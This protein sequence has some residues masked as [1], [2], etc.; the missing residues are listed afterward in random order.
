MSDRSTKGD[1]ISQYVGPLI[2]TD[3]R[4]WGHILEK[5]KQHSENSSNRSSALN[6]SFQVALCY[7]IG[8][9]ARRN[10]QKSSLWLERSQKSIA[11]LENE[12]RMLDNALTPG[13]R[14]MSDKIQS[15]SHEGFISSF[16]L[17]HEFRKAGSLSTLK[18]DTVN[19][20]TDLLEEFG[21]DHRLV[22]YQTIIQCDIFEAEGN[23]ASAEEGLTVILARIDKV[24]KSTSNKPPSFIVPVIYRL[25]SVLIAQNKLELAEE[26]TKDLVRSMERN[27]GPD[28]V[29]T[30]KAYVLYGQ[31]LLEKSEFKRAEEIL[32]Q[33]LHGLKRLLGDQHPSTLATRAKLQAVYLNLYD[34]EKLELAARDI[35]KVTGDTQEHEHIEHINSAANLSLALESQGK[36]REAKERGEQALAM[37]EKV[38]GLENATTLAIVGNLGILALRQRDLSASEVLLLRAI[39]GHDELFGKG[40]RDSLINLGHLAMVY[41]TRRD[42]PAAEEMH[43]RVVDGRRT[44]LAQ[45]HLSI[46]ISLANLADCL[47][48]AGKYEDAISTGKQALEGYE[49]ILGKASEPTIGMYRKLASLYEAQGLYKD[50]VSWYHCAHQGLK[51]LRGADHP[52]LMQNGLEM[53]IATRKLDSLAKAQALDIWPSADIQTRGSQ[54]LEARMRVLRTVAL[55]KQRQGDISEAG[56]IHQALIFAKEKSLGPSHPDTLVSMSDLGSLLTNKHDFA[57]AEALHGRVLRRRERALGPMHEDT[58]SSAS[59]MADVFKM[60]GRYDVAEDLYRRASVGREQVLGE[61]HFL[62]LISLNNLAIALMH[63]GELIEAQQL[64]ARVLKTRQRL[65]GNN[66]PH[67]MGSVNNLALIFRKQGNHAKAEQL[68]RQNLDTCKENLGNDHP[69]T[70]TAASNLVATLIHRQNHRT[71]EE[72][73]HDVRQKRESLLGED[74]PSTLSSIALAGR[75]LYLQ[76]HFSR[77]H[78]EYTHLI[79]ATVRVLGQDHPLT[80]SRQQEFEM[81]KERVADPWG[82]LPS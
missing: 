55:K 14:Y 15:W 41:Q 40:N 25:V 35:F 12:K 64:T 3:Y 4:V 28:Q 71:A 54:E 67:T 81:M 78:D 44:V 68:N 42:Y 66:H 32:H 46:F 69:S 50:A 30:L 76:G 36:Y 56:D 61:E 60:Q 16:E 13:D 21:P 29:G 49:M 51:A 53:K 72:L 62:T 33:A 5:L 77:A 70:L 82:V 47:D 52:D 1:Q 34:Y 19:I 73:N 74:D 6:A 18:A 2:L 58:L 43:R 7:R 80:A 22:W 10:L 24:R 26:Y 65:L 23:F 79:E 63:Q 48:E 8:F 11:D 17:V 39:E 9:G 27:Y 20:T 31:V 38:L 37:S 57:L 59:S 45:N 75:L